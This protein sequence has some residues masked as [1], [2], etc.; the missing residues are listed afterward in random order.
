M[1][2]V[3]SKGTTSSAVHKGMASAHM[4]AWNCMPALTTASTKC[5]LAFV[6]GQLKPP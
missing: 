5:S 3:W 6:E 1:S 4:R 2:A